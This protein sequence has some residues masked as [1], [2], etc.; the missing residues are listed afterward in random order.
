MLRALA[1]LDS[2]RSALQ[3]ADTPG[4]R[5]TC[6]AAA[7]GAPTLPRVQRA[8]LPWDPAAPPRDESEAAP[9]HLCHWDCWRPSGSLLRRTGTRP[10]SCGLEQLARIGG[11]RRRVRARSPRG[12]ARPASLRRRDGRTECR[13]ETT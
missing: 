3:G 7:V 8:A 10:P 1:E 5:E 2:P 4:R 6:C 9:T 12:D 11:F 13:R